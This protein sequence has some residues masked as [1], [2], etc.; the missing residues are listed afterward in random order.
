M[1]RND[2]KA[3]FFDKLVKS[4]REKAIGWMRKCYSLLSSAEC[5]DIFQDAS[6]EL[7]KK[8][9]SMKDWDGESWIGM[10]YGIC[11][12]MASHH[13][14]KLKPTEEWDDKFDSEVEEVDTDFGFISRDIFRM[15]QKERVYQVIE[16]L[17]PSDRALMLMHLQHMKMKDICKELGLGSPQVAK[18]KKCKIVA[19]LRK[20]IGGQEFTCPLF[21]FVTTEGT[22][23]YVL[24]GIFKEITP[25]GYHVDVQF[26][27]KAN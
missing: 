6:L 2:V 21:L 27:P 1:I 11:R 19:R 25:K 3:G 24:F 5:E 26:F 8:L 17:P 10:L 23:H 18:N 14:D 15:M 16:N 12:N 13:L 7:W 22:F 20:E 9:E 4:E